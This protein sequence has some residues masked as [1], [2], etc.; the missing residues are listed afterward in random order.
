MKLNLNGDRKWLLV[1]SVV[2]LAERRHPRSDVSVIRTAT[3]PRVAAESGARLYLGMRGLMRFVPNAMVPAKK[4]RKTSLERA[5][6][7]TPSY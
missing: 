6:K 1:L 4:R 5:V 2:D 3:V 7:E